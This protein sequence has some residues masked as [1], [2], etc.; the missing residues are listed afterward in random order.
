V[1]EGATSSPGFLLSDLGVRS[2]VLS[3][4]APVPPGEVGVLWLLSVLVREGAPS[5]SASF[6]FLPPKTRLRNPPV[7]VLL[8]VVPASLTSSTGEIER[9]QH[10]SCWKHGPTTEQQLRKEGSQ[11]DWW[12]ERQAAAEVPALGRTRGRRHNDQAMV[13]ACS[14]FYLLCFFRLVRCWLNEYSVWKRITM[15]ATCD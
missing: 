13:A 7:E 8:S 5:A 3:V 12:Q 1:G 11:Q 2:F 4:M 10:E 6:S 14:L 9:L 15:G